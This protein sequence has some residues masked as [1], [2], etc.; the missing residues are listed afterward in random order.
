MKLTFMQLRKYI[1]K[2]ATHD[3]RFLLNRSY[4]KKSALNLVSN[5]YLLS[6][7]ERNYM[8]RCVF[9]DS[10]SIFRRNKIVDISKIKGQS[11]LI[12]G[13]NVL[14]TVE[15]IFQED[16]ASI[17]LCDDGIIRDLN[18]V[19]G[20]Y[21]F[22]DKTKDVLTDILSLIKKYGPSE[23]KFFFDRQVS[24]SA[25]LANLTEEIIDFQGLKGEAILSKI[26]D[27]E[28]IKLSRAKNG[29]V[30]TSD[31]VI[32]DKVNRVVDLPFHFFRK[33]EN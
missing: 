9:S 5:K 14:I 13:Y 27:F 4:R 18:A 11:I 24:F 32:I 12:D 16:C 15:T 33:I 17:I 1:L 19:F 22:N 3:L 6:V 8:A 7:D 10:K 25:K 23:I 31:G 21:K 29:I 20:K 30:A 2:E 28:I 26:V